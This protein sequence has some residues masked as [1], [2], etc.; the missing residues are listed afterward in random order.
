MRPLLMKKNKQYETKTSDAI[1]YVNT[2]R[3]NTA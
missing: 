3:D 2:T 1:S